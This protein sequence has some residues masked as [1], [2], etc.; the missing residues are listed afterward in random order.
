M[1][2]KLLGYLA[3]LYKEATTT[4]IDIEGGEYTMR[5][6]RKGS[7]V[8]LMVES[9]QIKLELPMPDDKAWLIGGRLMDAAHEASAERSGDKS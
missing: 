9:E 3:R 8:V 1:R 2:G 5:V 4:S 7:R 6:E